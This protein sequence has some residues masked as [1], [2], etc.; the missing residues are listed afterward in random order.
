M[1]GE[2][3]SWRC[4]RAARME[5]A[6]LGLQ[7]D[8]ATVWLVVAAA[9]RRDGL[10]TAALPVLPGE[11]A[12]AGPCHYWRSDGVPPVHNADLI[13]PENLRGPPRSRPTVAGELPHAGCRRSGP[14]GYGCRHFMLVAQKLPLARPADNTLADLGGRQALCALFDHGLSTRG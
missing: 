12:R 14:Y 8:Y 7:T 10:R 11:P 1:G 3:R 9:L 6:A 2:P 13:A 4:D 5:I